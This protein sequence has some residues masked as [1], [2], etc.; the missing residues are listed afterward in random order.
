MAYDREVLHLD[1]MIDACESIYERESIENAIDCM[2]FCAA[3]WEAMGE[4]PKQTP[5]LA[6]MENI[7][8][9]YQGELAAAALFLSENAFSRAPEMLRGISTQL[10]KVNDGSTP[11]TVV[12]GFARFAKRIEHT[13][14]LQQNVITAI[15]KSE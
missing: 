14:Q 6:K 7:Y 11:T 2:N 3:L 12:K 5:D 4:D 8:D 1:G 9:G 10:S 15:A 13:R